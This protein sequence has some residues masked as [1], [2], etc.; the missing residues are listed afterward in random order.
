L[1]F[2]NQIS[3][4]LGS[5]TEFKLEYLQEA[6]LAVNF[7]DPQLNERAA[8]VMTQL[9]KNLQAQLEKRLMI[10]YIVNCV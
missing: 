9:K 4:D 6:L 10:K 8:S 5:S 1:T 7:Q 2:I 3:A